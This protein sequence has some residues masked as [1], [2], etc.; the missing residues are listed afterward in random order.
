[1]SLANMNITLADIV[2]F[3]GIFGLAVIIVATGQIYWLVRIM[4]SSFIALALVKIIP[5]SLIFKTEN[6]YL[7]YFLFFTIIIAIFSYNKLFN[8]VDWMGNRFNFGVIVFAFFVILFF[9]ATIFHFLN[10]GYFKGIFTGNVYNILHD[11][12]FYFALIPL[13][14]SLFFSKR[15]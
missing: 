1:M 2:L 8:A 6:S 3:L 7:F 10:Y 5:R 13:I 11:N 15:F 12:L 9:I 14:F 4:V